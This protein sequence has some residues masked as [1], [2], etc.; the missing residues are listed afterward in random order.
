MVARMTDVPGIEQGRVGAWLAGCLG[1]F[2]PPLSFIR[3][4]EGQSNLTFRVT[5]AGGRTVIVRRPPLGVILASAHDVAREYRILTA[6]SSAGA[7][8]PR[9]FAL[10]TDLEVTGAPFYAMEDVDG[11]VLSH[12]AVAEQL[13]RSAR[14]S[15]ARELAT[16]LATFHALD[17]TEIG[18]ADLTR[19]ESLVSRQLRRW[20]RQ[21]DASK[22][23]ELPLIDALAE[24]FAAALPEERE[25]V[26]VHG[27]Y[28]LGNA[29]VGPSGDIRAILDWE[30]CSVGDPMADVGLFVAYWNEFGAAGSDRGGLFREAV[31][32]LSGFPTAAELVDEYARSSQRQL[33]NLGFWV[34]F[35]YWK[36]AVIVEGVYRRWLIDP[37]NGS[38]AGTL[39]PAVARLAALAEQAFGAGDVF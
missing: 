1:D 38:E 7:R 27:D 37:Q 30:L 26:L 29:L 2:V 36:I 8:V 9:T 34:A 5:D 6:L 18:L 23:R 21:W 31:T 25:S 32:A 16:T 12:V 24:R 22:T 10:C 15:V 33:D 11:L 35:A 13:T 19:P 17:V 14:S 28:H 39:Q 3:V 20:R 4:G